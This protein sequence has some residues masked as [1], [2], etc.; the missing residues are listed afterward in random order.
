M[1]KKWKATNDYVYL[2]E[3]LKS[4]RQDLTVCFIDAVLYVMRHLHHG[5]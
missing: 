4:I 2:C 1:Q 3:Q 5:L